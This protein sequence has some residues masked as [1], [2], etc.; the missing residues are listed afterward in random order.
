MLRGWRTQRI[1]TLVLLLI[2]LGLPLPSALHA[3]EATLSE[4]IVTNT[5]EDLLVFFEIKGCFTRQMEEAILNGI[6][7]T[8]TIFV[9]L[10]RTRTFWLDET[11]ASLK[12]EHTIK[13]DSLK[14]EF[15][16]RRSEDHGRERVYRSF[17]AAKTA[18]AEV[19]NIKIAPLEALRK[20]GKYQLQVKAELEKVRLPFYLHYVLFFVSLWDFETDWYS[21]DFTY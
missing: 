2:L 15:R 21:V 3:S 10:Y 19:K 8:F 20:H 13:H 5:Q 4:I 6:P 1:L 18:M 11:I 17:A 9:N 16:V 14:K 12:I 7:T